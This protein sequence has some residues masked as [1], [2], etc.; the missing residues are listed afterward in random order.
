MSPYLVDTNFFISAY[1]I[2]FPIDVVP[3]YW[4][5]V[6]EMAANGDIISIDKVKNEIYQ[7]E[8]DLKRWCEAN[9][10]QDFFKKSLRYAKD[11]AAYTRIVEWAN[12]KINSPYSQ[13]ALNTFLD[14]DEADAFLVTYATANGY[15]IVTNEVSAPDSKKIIKIPDVCI[16]LNVPYLQSMAMLRALGVKI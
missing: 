13:A 6:K 8:D 12:S 15:C 11:I 2:G 4:E 7:N 10:P 16:A 1:R 5:K 9:L 3:T 14:A